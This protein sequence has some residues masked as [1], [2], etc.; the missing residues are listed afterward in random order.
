MFRAISLISLPILIWLST[1]QVTQLLAGQA[2]PTPLNWL[3]VITTGLVTLTVL[4]ISIVVWRSPVTRQ[5][6]HDQHAA[7]TAANDLL[8]DHFTQHPDRQEA[9]RVVARHVIEQRYERPAS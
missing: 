1:C 7:L 4:T 6:P 2:P 9:V 8:F 3:I 5:P